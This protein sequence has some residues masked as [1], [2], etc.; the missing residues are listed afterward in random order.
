L[1][2]PLKVLL[3]YPECP[4]SFW[5][6]THAMRFLGRRA[7]VPPLGLLT[8][9]ALL[10]NTWEKR[11][12]DLNVCTWSD[13]DLH[14][15]DMVF[16]GGMVVQRDSAQR[17]ITRSKA[18]GKTVVAGGP[19]FL[20]EHELFPQVDHFVLN[21]AELTLPLFLADLAAGTAK[22]MYRSSAFA[23]LS[24]SPVPLWGLA[25][26]K[27]YVYMGVQF[28][29]GCPFDCDFCD[30]TAMLGRRPRVK[31][32][33]QVMA[34]LD[35]LESAGWKGP[36]FFQKTHRPMAFNTQA[37]INL[38]DDPALTEQMVRAGFDSVFVGIE[39]PSHSALAECGKSQN[40]KRD[41]VADVRKLQRAGLEVQ[42]GFIVGFDTDDASIFQRMVSFIQ[43]SGVVTA[44]VGLLQAPPTTRLAQRLRL[45]GRLTGP[46]TGDNTDGTTNIT[47]LMGLETIRNGY[48]RML[49]Q[50]YQ[51]APYYQRVRQL[52]RELG[53]RPVSRPHPTM[54]QLLAAARSMIRL[55]FLERGRMEYWKLLLWLVPRGPS[56]WVDGL[57]LAIIG[58]HYR[59]IASV[60]VGRIENQTYVQDTFD[61]LLARLTAINVPT[62]VSNDAV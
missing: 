54:R 27:W 58:H 22:R 2:A 55:G 18:A 15:A 25:Q 3:V 39:T 36:V 21:E 16:V 56:R 38:A 62:S 29:R 33:Q 47:P 60:V 31:S 59:K 48:A 11:L 43:Q 20:N 8:V 24:T 30:I 4:V 40:Q 28:S 26:L 12:V 35:A 19:L 34:E 44:M 32:A 23:D 41:L 50:L 6:Y 61:A 51:P 1:E 53:K 52:L 49:K 14:W 13:D 57:R 46:T 42:A 45:L 5:S 17:V 7:V 10:P 9:A 37:S